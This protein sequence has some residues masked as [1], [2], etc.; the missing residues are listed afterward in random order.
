MTQDQ[1]N[2]YKI[3]E[4][5]LT[6][7]TNLSDKS[8][9]EPQVFSCGSRDPKINFTLQE[10]HSEFYTEVSRAFEKAKRQVSEQVKAI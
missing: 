2:D 10:I 6:R 1:I 8:P 7:L 3:C 5:Y 9:V 4:T